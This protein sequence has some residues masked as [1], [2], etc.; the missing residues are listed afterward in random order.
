MKTLKLNLLERTLIELA[1]GDRLTAIRREIR[2]AKQ[3]GREDI[4]AELAG[5]EAQTDALHAKLKADRGA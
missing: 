4:A 1:L 3:Q 5:L 2:E